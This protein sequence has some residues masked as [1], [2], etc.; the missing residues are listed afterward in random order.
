MKK[1]N[2][3][4]SRLILRLKVGFDGATGQAIY[5]QLVPDQDVRNLS[6]EG[7]PFII[8]FIPLELIGF[9]GSEKKMIRLNPRTSSKLFCRLIWFRYVKE[10]SEVKEEE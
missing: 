4:V 10:T 3:C 2:E 1:C 7:S 9:I 8:S 6:I 5:K